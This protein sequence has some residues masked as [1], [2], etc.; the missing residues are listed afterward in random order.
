MPEATHNVTIKRPAAEVFAFIADGE[1]A[2]KWRSGVK[3]IERVSGDGVGAV[4]RQRVSGP[5]GRSVSADYEVTKYDPNSLLAFKTIAGPV[6]PTGEFRLSEDGGSTALT[7]SLR[8]DLSGL[9]KLFMSGAVQRTMDSEVRAIE[10]A[11]DLL[12]S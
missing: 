4:Y 1:N 10:N 8:A 12:E 3:E 5:G 2:A 9:K 7:F 6:R 11:R